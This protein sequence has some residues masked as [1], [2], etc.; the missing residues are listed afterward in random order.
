MKGNKR[1]GDKKANTGP[2]ITKVSTYATGTGSVK[3][4]I[5]RGAARHLGLRGGDYA[6]WTATTLN[7]GPLVIIGR[8]DAS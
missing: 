8:L 5:P 6:G 4:T 2:E 7:G 1:K 3:S